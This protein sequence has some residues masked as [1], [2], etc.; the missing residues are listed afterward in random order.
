MQWT[1]PSISENLVKNIICGK[2]NNKIRF[3]MLRSCDNIFDLVKIEAIYLHLN[4]PNLCKQ[5]DFGY[6][7]SLFN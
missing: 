2:N 7:I 6:S 4:K 3:K 1:E 5:K